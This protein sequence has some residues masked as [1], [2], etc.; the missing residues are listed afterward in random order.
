MIMPIICSGSV[1]SCEIMI[2]CSTVLV[3]RLQDFANELAVH[4]SRTPYPFTF[5]P[6][7]STRRLSPSILHVIYCWGGIGNWPCL[8]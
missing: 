3:I 7:H 1:Y 8:S 6:T 4:I 2:L 5:L